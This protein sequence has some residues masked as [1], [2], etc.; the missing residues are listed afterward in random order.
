M[1]ESMDGWMNSVRA[2]STGAA[3]T[4]QH[5]HSG[6]NHYQGVVHGTMRS[7]ET[8]EARSGCSCE[9]MDPQVMHAGAPNVRCNS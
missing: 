6:S 4:T 8:H 9:L 3:S 2:N 7:P 5:K 1:D